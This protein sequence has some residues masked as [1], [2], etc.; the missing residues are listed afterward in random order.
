MVVPRKPSWAAG[1]GHE[2]IGLSSPVTPSYRPPVLESIVGDLPWLVMLVS[3]FI[4]RGREEQVIARF[5]DAKAA[6]VCSEALR[7][8]YVVPAVV[9]HVSEK[10]EAR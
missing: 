1:N 9:R 6:R 10:E 5:R 8:V 3:N 4:G 2:G 7:N